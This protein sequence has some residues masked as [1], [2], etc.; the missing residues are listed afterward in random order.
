MRFSEYKKER[1]VTHCADIGELEVYNP[2]NSKLIKLIRD[3]RSYIADYDG[4]GDY[5]HVFPIGYDNIH[6]YIVCPFC[7]EIH[8]HG[9]SNSNGHRVSH[10]R[11]L[12]NKGYVILAKRTGISA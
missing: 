8:I 1:D 2:P 10:C 5:W 11:E 12:N 4:F 3:E 6:V 9:R 7:G